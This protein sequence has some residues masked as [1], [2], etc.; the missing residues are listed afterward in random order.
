M[1]R[2]KNILILLLMAMITACSSSSGGGG[3]DNP[4]S[5]NDDDPPP[6]NPTA[7]ALIFPEDDSECNTG[8]VVSDTETNVTFEWSASQN[9]DSYQLNIL[10]LDTNN[11]TTTTVSGTEATVLIERAT[12]YEWFVVSSASGTNSTATSERWRFYNEG[13]GVEN[14]APFP[15]EAVAPQR[16]INLSASTTAI[17]L[18][19][20]ASDVD[21]DITSYE[22]F[23]DTSE[24]P[25]TS[26][27]TFSEAT[28]ADVAVTSGNTY[29]WKVTTFDSAGNSSTSEIFEFRVL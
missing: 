19:W 11:S 8:A 18:E 20:N 9:T 24:N 23:L 14:Y 7:A 3:D 26:L 2:N 10:N 5:G 13:L 25:T 15:A 12:P 28:I 16:G 21:D 4:M 27:G 17:S 29:Y 6:P 1:K 22:V